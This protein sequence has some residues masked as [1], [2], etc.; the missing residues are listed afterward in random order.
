MAVLED[1]SNGWGTTALVG[2][3]AIVATPVL[4]PVLAGC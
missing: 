3:G 1:L 2:L 4:L